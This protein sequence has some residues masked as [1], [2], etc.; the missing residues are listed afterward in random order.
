VFGNVHTGLPPARSTVDNRLQARLAE[1]GVRRI[2]FHDLRH[3][4]GTPIAA[5]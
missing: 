3:T 1:A 2:R 5:R 4:Y